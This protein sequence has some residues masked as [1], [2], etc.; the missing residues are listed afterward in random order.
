MSSRYILA[1]DLG[2]SGPKVALVATEGT[3]V[4][5]ASAPIRLLYVPG[6]GVEQ[7]PAEWW[8]AIC[9]ATRQLLAQNLV[10][11]PAIAGVCVTSQWSG[12]VA[13][14]AG[15]RPL[16]NA[17][18]WMDD[19]GARHIRRVTGGALA[20]QGYGVTK[21]WAWLRK[22][23]GIPTHSGKDAI[24]HILYIQQERPE[25]YTR[26]YKFLEPKDYL[27]LKL[28]GCFAA[29]FE[30]IALHWVTDNR[31]IDNVHYDDQLL[32]LAG[33]DRALLPDLCRAVDI[34]GPLTPEAADDLGLGRHVQVIA[35]TPDLHSAA[36][37][38][39][40]VDDYAAHYYIG[41]SAWINCHLPFKR[42]DLI[43]N[44]ASLPS[45]IPGRYLLINEHETAG[46]ALTFLRD[47]VFFPD[48]G[49][50]DQAAP[51]D[52][53][54]RIEALASAAPAGSNRL[55][56]T[57]WLHGERSPVD[58]RTLRGGWHNLSMR[59]TRGDMVRAVYEGVALNAAWLFEYV[60]KFVKRRI[61]TLSIVGGGARSAH[62][63]QIH[64]DVLQ[65]RVLQ[66]ADPLH[67]NTRGAG[68]LGAVGLGD[69]TFD[70]IGART[71][72]AAVFE[73]DPQHG[74]L[75]AELYA[76]FVELY[77]KNRGLYA[78]LNRS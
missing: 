62:W 24:A 7:D 38:S 18:I 1:I 11:V 36:L 52:F 6:G 27:N 37:G 56:F 34:L 60:E 57:P 39:G 70:A 13:V 29:T 20:F 64:A 32:R 41:T 22:T 21:L 40:A 58:D 73:P 3:I 77:R 33:I 59:T 51:D 67:T 15:G 53:F 26:T 50:L 68:Y 72:I 10:P 65:R 23:G 14:D 12:T 71:P 43:H 54:D 4:G 46:A 25:I 35:G 75:Y 44:M 55:L 74:M 19:R 28:T 9:M 8:R 5:G 16:M 66:I 17:I 30:S 42:T 49:L 2:T 63:C 78:R 31:D 69:L 76:A 61:D 45:A 48:D 47:N